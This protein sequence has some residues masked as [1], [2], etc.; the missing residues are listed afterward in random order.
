ME[1]RT[2]EL[3]EKTYSEFVEFRNEM[4]GFKDEMTDGTKRKTAS[5]NDERV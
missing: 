2:F 3:L 1:D 5:R 4:T